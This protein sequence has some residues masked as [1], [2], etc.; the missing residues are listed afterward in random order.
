MRFNPI[1]AKGQRCDVCGTTYRYIETGSC[2]NCTRKT[3]KDNS[4]MELVNRR[5]KLEKETENKK[6]NN[7]LYFE[8]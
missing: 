4:N 1:I 2:V 7:D 8:D 3:Y 6:I 5:R